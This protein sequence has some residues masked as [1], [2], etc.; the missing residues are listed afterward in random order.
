MYTNT[1]MYTIP[2]C[3]N[4]SLQVTI[5]FYCCCIDWQTFENVSLESTI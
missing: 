2:G 4:I 1:E 5:E 3:M